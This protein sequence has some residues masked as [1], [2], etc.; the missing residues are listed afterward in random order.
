MSNSTTSFLYFRFNSFR[1]SSSKSSPSFNLSKVKNTPSMSL[2]NLRPKAEEMK[3][4]FDKFDTNKDGKISQEEYKSAMKMM[5]SGGNTKTYDV[6]DAFQAADTDGDGFINFEEFMRVQN[7]EGG[8]NPTDIKS[9]FEAFDLDG[10]GKISAEELLQ[11]QRMLGEKCS[12]ENCKK[13]VRGVDANGDGLID[14][15]E[16]V[17]MMTRTMKLV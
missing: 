7:L 11:V 4:V 3:R 5:G 8:V 1:K 15:D 13:M 16:F 6:G 14:M 2:P 10:D 9:A 17:T 12:L